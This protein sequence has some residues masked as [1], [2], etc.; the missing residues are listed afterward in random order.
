MPHVFNYSEFRTRTRKYNKH[1]NIHQEFP[2]IDPPTETNNSVHGN[3][4]DEISQLNDEAFYKGQ[5]FG[6][7]NE[8]LFGYNND[9]ND[10]NISSSDERDMT[11]FEFPNMDSMVQ[12]LSAMHQEL[13]MGY[14]GNFQS[15]VLDQAVNLNQ[16]MIPF[17]NWT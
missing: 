8:L 9:Y 2:I 16:V 10:I 1:K 15:L 3:N 4:V 14:N 7:V 6:L 13:G 12:D 17:L 5:T 11:T